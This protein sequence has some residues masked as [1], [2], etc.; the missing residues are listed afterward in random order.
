MTLI[1]LEYIIAVDNHRHFGRA[2]ESCFVT[3][4][5]LSMQIHKL[6][7]QLGILIFDR[8]KSPISP[9][10]IGRRIIDQGR[11][12]VNEAKKM[13]HLIDE[14]KGEVAGELRIGIIPTLSPYLLP[15]FIHNFIEKYPAIKLTVEELVT[16]Q[17]IDK[18]KM[19]QLDIAI[20]VTPYD[21]PNLITKPIF[22][23]E[24]F[25]YVS[26]RSRFFE[27]EMLS[28]NSIPANELWLLNEGHCFR[29]QVLNLCHTYKDRDA[30]FKY[31][32]GSLEALKK[33]VDRHGGVTL[34][35]ELATLD[36]DKSSQARVRPFED[37]K[38]V[39]EVSLV[40]HK[41]FLKRK[42]AEALYK[43]ILDAIPDYINIQKHGKVI[44][45]K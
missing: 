39:R 31:E 2:A 21:D 24:F 20:I 27:Q 5:T 14:E 7:E 9:T 45:W 3:Q 29:D 43:E 11:I 12:V 25:A 37:P 38:P 32:S 22:Y 4:P 33:I 23:E 30:S 35:P 42:L 28:I 1:Q 6:E 13:Q 8:S 26:H 16:E 34:L 15:L 10:D 36:F 18:L 41:S 17:V 44:K 40:M 19:E